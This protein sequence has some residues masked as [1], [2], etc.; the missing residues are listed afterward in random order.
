MT[1]APPPPDIERIVAGLT[2]AERLLIPHMS[3]GEFVYPVSFTAADA[4]VPDKEARKA[5]RHLR[6]IG[7][8]QYGVLYNEDE[9]CP[10][11]SG[12]WLTPLGLQVRAALQET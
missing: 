6:E 9:Y 2:E 10:A 5:F 3:D 1:A 7:L 8:A 4:G 12:T 11:G